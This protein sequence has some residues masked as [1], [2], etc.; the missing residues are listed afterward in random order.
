MLLSITFRGKEDKQIKTSTS[1]GWST[2]GNKG[3]GWIDFNL[4]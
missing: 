4:T 3:E 2:G 1:L